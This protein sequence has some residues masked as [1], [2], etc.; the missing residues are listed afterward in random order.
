MSELDTFPKMLRHQAGRIADRP[1]IME[2][3]YG[4]WQTWSWSDYRDE[5]NR[6]AAG[7]SSLGFKRGDKLFII[8]Q[9]RPRLYF[10]IAA[11][12]ALGGVPVPTY[13]D[14][15]AE[16]MKFV[17][18][19]A[20]ARF[21]LAE[22]QEQ[23]DKV[24]EVK[25]ECPHV[26]MIIYDDERGLS[27]YD[28]DIV[29]SFESI[30]S[31]GDEQL[32]TDTRLVEREIDE[33]KGTDTSVILYTS[34]TTGQPKGVVLTY[35][36]IRS[37][38]QVCVDLEG[39]DENDSVIAYLPMAWI[40]D[41]FISY[42]QAHIAGF[43]VCCPE[44]EA[45]VMQ[46]SREI[47][48]TYHF[49]SPRVLENQRT[50][51]M[52][53]MEDASALKRRM[54]HYFLD[55]AKRCLEARLGGRE[56]GLK[57]RILY[58]IGKFLV[59]EPLKNQLGYSRTRLTYTA[60]EAIGPDMF[61][62]YR[63]IGIHLK[64]VYGQT[65]ASPFVTVQPNDEV[66][67]DTVGKPIE[68]VEIKLSEDGEVLF[69]SPGV[70]HSY[71]K[72]PESTASAKTEDGW[73]RTGDAGIFDHAGHLKIIDRTKDVGRLNNGSLFAPKYIEN[74][75]KFFPYILEAVAIGDNRD[76][77]TAFINIDLSAVG[78]WAERRG[79][80][81]SSYQELAAHP[82]TYDLIEQCLEKVNADLAEDDMLAD[83][84]VRRFLILHKELDADDG[85]LTRT[86]KL[87][88]RIIAERYDPLIKALYDGSEHCELSVEVT[89]ED[90]RKGSLKG[91]LRI[92]PVKVFDKMA[93]SA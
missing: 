73:V 6:F 2:K 22:D 15:V 9:N 77:V 86:R 52:I 75:L 69:R 59:Y 21:V 71:Y 4:I 49:T 53:R 41:H 56:I 14:S 20:G 88:R 43:C 68:G 13:Y 7:L 84:Q 93:R 63:S 67:S 47:G 55:V 44:S 57:D 72:N 46:D 82:D 78:D 62:F 11:A 45:T 91:D 61:D 24:L 1:A 36:N 16:E 29:R 10:A 8:G 65:E 28:P 81:Y 33:G 34:G 42:A 79:L 87:R 37:I 90:G 85:E 64:Q 27:G 12:Q 89:F 32:A 74:K 18:G 92:V 50:S 51:I 58:A 23:V 3:D 19:H 40:V 54:F 35:D 70:F 25:D 80:A 48:P 38:A 31:L 76:E 5:V 26:E 60:G 83:S 30:Q 17:I 66:R 39:L